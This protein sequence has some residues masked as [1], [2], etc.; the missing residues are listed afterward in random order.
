MATP[1][2]I[3]PVATPVVSEPVATPPIPPPPPPP[4]APAQLELSGILTTMI[5]LMI[6]MVMLSLIFR[7]FEEVY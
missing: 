1:I 6:V 7:Q 3:A 5:P 2:Y 4:A